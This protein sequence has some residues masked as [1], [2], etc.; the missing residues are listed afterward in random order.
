MNRLV[1]STVFF[2]L[3]VLLVTV[4]DGCRKEE[5]ITT[6]QN[7][8]VKVIETHYTLG[9]QY[10]HKTSRPPVVSQGTAYYFLFQLEHQ[11]LYDWQGRITMHKQ[12]DFDN[13]FDGIEINW[14]TYPGNQAIWRTSLTNGQ[15]TL[16]L[17]KWGYYVRLHAAQVYTYNDEGY[18]LRSESSYETIT[19]TVV[20]GNLTE[21][22]TEN[23]TY[24]GRKTVGQYE[25]DLNHYSLINPLALF[26]EGRGSR[27]L[28]TRSTSKIDY[29]NNGGYKNDPLFLSSSYT[30]QFDER[31]RVKQQTILD[32]T[33]S[34]QKN[35]LT[36]KQF[37]YSD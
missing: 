8:L 15:D 21:A 14:Y 6:R 19:N 18:L 26:S 5:P 33:S 3:V 35:L 12:T 11:Y 30:Y 29:E 37:V 22:I 10:I 28:L 32:S 31:D 1:Q 2:L 7:R 20:N 16:T 34:R 27:N 23:N 13:S 17:N 24:V 9:S 4:T 36:I 25:Y